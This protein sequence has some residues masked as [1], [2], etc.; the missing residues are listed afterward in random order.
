MILEDRVNAILRPTRHQKEVLAKIRG[1]A[2]PE[3]AAANVSQD[4]HLVAARDLLVKLGL[5][6][7]QDGQASITPR[8]EEVMRNQNLIDETGQ[9]TPEAQQMVSGAKEAQPTQESLLRTINSLV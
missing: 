4:A 1:A 5:I 9:L 6:E 8:G 2:T 7:V 3:T